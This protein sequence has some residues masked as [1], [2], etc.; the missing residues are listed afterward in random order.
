[1]QRRSVVTA[2]V[3]LYDD[4]HVLIQRHEKTQ[5]TLHGK[6]TELA[7]EHLGYIGLANAK[8]VSGFHLFQAAL[9]HDGVN[10]EHQLSFDKMLICISHPDVLEH[11]PAADLIRLPAHGCLW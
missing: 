4:L 6:L 1:M 2:T 7:S 8:Q 11:I 5:K 3:R 10:L 9:F